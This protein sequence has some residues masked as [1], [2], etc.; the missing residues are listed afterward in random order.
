ML[1]F[2]DKNHPGAQHASF[3]TFQGVIALI[4]PRITRPFVQEFPPGFIHPVSMIN[5]YW[6]L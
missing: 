6:K 1:N 3:D 2:A 5:R 4:A